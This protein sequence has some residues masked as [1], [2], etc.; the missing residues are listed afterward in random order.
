MP[1]GTL[2]PILSRLTRAVLSIVIESR[3]YD[4]LKAGQRLARRTLAWQAGAAAILALLFLV[5]GVAHATSA[6]L[7]GVAVLLG[8]IVSARLM[9][10]GGVQPAASVLVRWFIGALAKWIVVGAVLLS[11]L[12][13][14][15][16]PP[17]PLL[18]GLVL[19]LGVQMYAMTRR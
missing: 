18:L 1:V 2:Q 11:G 7:G 3:V 6:L 17:L 10:G 8:G 15:R 13:V 12:V 16:L 5:Q 9:V 14:W 19:G 4:P